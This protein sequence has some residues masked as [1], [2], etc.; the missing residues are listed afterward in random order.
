MN[1]I[2]D[3]KQA[4]IPECKGFL[5]TVSLRGFG[6]FSELTLDLSAGLNVLTGMNGTGK[7]HFLQFVRAGLTAPA[8]RDLS[9]HFSGLLTS[10]EGSSSFLLHRLSAVAEGRLKLSEEK[11]VLRTFVAEKVRKKDVEIRIKEEATGEPVPFQPKSVF[12]FPSEKDIPDL[13]SEKP[14]VYR[15][16]FVRLVEKTMP[17]RVCRRNGSFWIKNAR[18]WSP[19]AQVTPAT[20]QLGLLSL[21]LRQGRLIPGSVLL[22]DSPEGMFGPLLMGELV[23]ILLFLSR[24]GVQVLVATRDYVFLKETDLRQANGDAVLY[25]CFYRND[26]LDRIDAESSSSLSGLSR[27]P[28]SDALRS[29]FDRDID[30]AMDKRWSL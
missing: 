24:S 2:K 3:R 14:G 20:R 10:P 15:S 30:R 27:N 1:P 25:H 29:L 7:S 6:A 19:W 4:G 16:R 23:E 13:F 22:W 5:K 11:K 12:F 17:G 9:R 18:G 28:A 21:I 8:A 26:R